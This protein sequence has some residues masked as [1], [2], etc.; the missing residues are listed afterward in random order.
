MAGGEISHQ[1]CY[2]SPERRGDG[3]RLPSCKAKYPEAT[4]PMIV[5]R[6]DMATSGLLLVAKAKSSSTLGN[7]SSIALRSVM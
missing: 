4:G 1:V 5:H 2:L 3:F 6:L 7:S